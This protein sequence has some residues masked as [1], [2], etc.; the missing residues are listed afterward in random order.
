MTRRKRGTRS[1]AGFVQHRVEQ[2]VQRLHR[3][4]V[5]TTLDEFKD[6]LIAFRD[7]GVDFLGAD[8]ERRGRGDVHGDLAADGV[9]GFLVAGRLQRDEHAE[10]VSA[11]EM[12]VRVDMHSDPA[13]L[14]Q[15][16][17]KVIGAIPGVATMMSTPRR[18]V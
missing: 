17:N 12:L 4:G 18:S 10:P 1:V 14:R 8:G 7:G 11:S 13:R 16:I 9:Q 3:A 15:E 2:R 5:Y 6:A